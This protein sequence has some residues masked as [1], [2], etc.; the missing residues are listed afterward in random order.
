MKFKKLSLDESL[1]DD[2]SGIKWIP[3]TDIF[4]DNTDNMI[5]SI[6]DDVFEI[7]DQDEHSTENVPSGPNSGSDFGVTSEF[8]ALINDEWEAIQGYNN[9]VETLKSLSSENP[10]YLEAVKVLE[11]ISAEEN[12]HVGQLQELLKRISPN[13]SEIKEGEQEAKSQLRFVNGK[14]PVETHTPIVSGQQAVTPGTEDLNETCTL[15][16]CDDEF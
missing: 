3:A 4:G 11:E 15:D 12:R 1:F 8:I 5:A 16:D 6:D 14:L 7:V 10:F 2:D 9:T 13:A